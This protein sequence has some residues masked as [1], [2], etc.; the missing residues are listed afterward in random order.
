M[1]HDVYYKE[2]YNLERQT[3]L[4]NT[5]GLIT[6]VFIRGYG[7]TEDGV[8]NEAL[9]I[10]SDQP[11]F[12]QLR[13]ASLVKVKLLSRLNDERARLACRREGHSSTRGTNWKA[14][15]RREYGI[16]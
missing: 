11:L 5:L 9:G 3:D 8:I 16:R 13:T 10:G 2:A 14:E 6:V 4:T 7:S 15:G 1:S 12:I